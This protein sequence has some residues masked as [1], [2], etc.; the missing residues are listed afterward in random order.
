MQFC[1]FY[2][3]LIYICF[4][5]YWEFT[6]HLI[7]VKIL[8]YARAI[9]KTSVFLECS[10]SLKEWEL[11]IVI[12]CSPGLNAVVQSKDAVFLSLVWTRVQ[13]YKNSTPITN[14]WKRRFTYLFYIYNVPWQRIHKPGLFWN[15]SRNLVGSHRMLIRLKHKTFWSML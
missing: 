13:S 4:S 3:N 9:E 1:N 12:D 14:L 6:V 7:C 5:N 8:P 15:L 11:Y 10:R 2:T